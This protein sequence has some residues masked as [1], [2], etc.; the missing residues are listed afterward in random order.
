M[1]IYSRIILTFSVL[2]VY[3]CAATSAP[4]PNIYWPSPPEEPR[5]AYLNS[6][7]GDIDLKK[8]GIWDMLFG[9]ETRPQMIKPYGVTSFGEKIYVTNTGNG[10]VLILDLKEKKAG[11]LGGG[12][13]LP[14]GIAAAPDGTIFVSDAKQR[15]IFG[16]GADGNLKVAFSDKTLQSP[17]GVAVDAELGRVYVVDSAGHQFFTFSLKGQVLFKVGSRG[18]GNAEFNYPSNIAVDRKSHN[19]YVV[20][21]QNFRIQIFDKD[22]NFL[23]R[24]G[25]VGDIA[26]SFTRPKGIGIDS[27]GHVFVSDA[28]FANFQIFN[29]Q[30]ELLL[31]VGGHGTG[32]GA[33]VLPAALY[34]DEND[35]VYMV[36][37]LDPRVQVFQYLSANWKMEHPEEYKKYLL[38]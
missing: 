10:T 36:D 7:R 35:R 9:V 24:F 8:I 1:K 29:E 32:P 27:E 18:E 19:I 33:F 22:G 25:S 28:A 16:Y 30:G 31:F 23:R 20:D 15:K 5:I 26:G 17:A 38:P 14:I 11:Y 2:I 4:R 21:T 6:Y 13:G 37:Q 12:F 34:I 3:G